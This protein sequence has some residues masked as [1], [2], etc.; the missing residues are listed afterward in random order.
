MFNPGPNLYRVD[1]KYGRNEATLTIIRILFLKF[2]LRR[3]ETIRD[4]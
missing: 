2:I 1:G 4:T 3:V